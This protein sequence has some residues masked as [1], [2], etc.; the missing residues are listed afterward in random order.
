MQEDP[1]PKIHESI[2]SVETDSKYSNWSGTKGGGFSDDN[3]S[4]SAPWYLTWIEVLPKIGIWSLEDWLKRLATPS[5]PHQIRLLTWYLLKDLGRRRKCI[6][7]LEHYESMKL[8]L[9][10]HKGLFVGQVMAHWQ[11]SCCT[12]VSSL[13]GVSFLDRLTAARI[14]Q[15]AAGVFAPD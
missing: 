11:K 3:R 4:S 1:L 12:G 13:I 15:A 2:E 14:E 5:L 6:L 8:L 10:H 7:C 9:M